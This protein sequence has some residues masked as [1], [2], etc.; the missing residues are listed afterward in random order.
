VIEWTQME[1]AALMSFVAADGPVR[2]GLMKFTEDR[3]QQSKALCTLSM[4]TVPRNPELASDYAAKA[5]V[6]DEFWE[7]LTSALEAELRGV[8]TAAE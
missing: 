1:R 8:P 4:A 5:Q 6:Y 3:S 2:N 7:A